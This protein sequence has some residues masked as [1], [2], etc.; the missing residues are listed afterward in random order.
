MRIFA[1]SLIIA[2]LLIFGGCQNETLTECQQRLEQARQELTET[3]KELENEKAAFAKAKTDLT[4]Q[5]SE[6]KEE[7]TF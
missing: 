6:K 2:G 5:I 4:S 1:L 3:K 7:L